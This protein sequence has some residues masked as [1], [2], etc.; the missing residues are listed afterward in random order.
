MQRNRDRSPPVPLPGPCNLALP[1]FLIHLQGHLADTPTADNMR[2]IMIEGIQNWFLTGDTNDPESADPTNQIGWFQDATRV[3][4]SA[5]GFLPEQGKSLKYCTGELWTKQLIAFLWTHS[6]TLWND[7]CVVAHAPAE[8]SP[9]NSSARSRQASQQRVDTAF[10]YAP[11]MLAR[12]RRVL[13]IP[14]EERLKSRT[15]ALVA[16]V[17]TIF[18]VNNQSVRDARA[19]IHTGH[20]DIRSYFS[21]AAAAA[22]ATFS[23][24]LSGRMNQDS[25]DL[26]RHTPILSRWQQQRINPKDRQ[27]HH[28]HV[29]ELTNFI[30]GR[31]FTLAAGSGRTN[32]NH[33]IDA[34]GLLN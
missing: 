33:G 5:R 29:H 27:Q 16:W 7:R 26:C 25:H 12:D 6:Q 3:E 32:P 15:S 20:Q 18:P 31:G 34:A 9:D 10:A 21:D 28:V 13:D 24:A 14:L 2:D 8:D 4:H 11:L 30:A 19:E 22:T 17:K 23:A 1:A